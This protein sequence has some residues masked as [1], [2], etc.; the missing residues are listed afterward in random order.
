MEQK[1]RDR[2]AALEQ[3]TGVRILY[4]VESG[5][6]AWGFA[7]RDSDYD[8]R[9]IYVQPLRRYLSVFPGRDTIELMEQEGLFD[10]SGWEL[11]KALGLFH[12][13]N[14]PL[15]EW[16]RSPIIYSEPGSF[17]SRLRRLSR[18]YFSPRSCFHHYLS[19]AAGNFREY[20]KGDQVRLKKYLYVLRPTL[21][22]R[23]IEQTGEFPPM[24]FIRLLDEDR[25]DE[26][27]TDEIRALLARKIDGDELGQGPAIIPISRFLER[28]LERLGQIAGQLPVAPRPSPRTLDSVMMACLAE[29]GVERELT[30]EENP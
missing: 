22:C 23:W 1:I 19:M 6:R 2:L 3:E 26:T 5:S 8:V 12:K 10:L 4:A 13:S 18:E 11:R 9:F 20:L 27:V 17:A 25:L 16:L 29:S 15:L 24:E 21:A 14:P 7:S 28:E 30:P